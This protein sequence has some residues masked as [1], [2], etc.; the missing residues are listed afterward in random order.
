MAGNQTQ[1]EPN[2]VSAAVGLAVRQQRL[3]ADL[4]LRDL[5]ARSGV[6]SAMISRIEN[7]QVSPSLSTLEA[8]AAAL[9]VP[10]V[11]L[12]EHTLRAADINF[13]KS[14][15][16][17]PAVRIAPGHLHRYKMLGHHANAALDFTASMVTLDKS[18]DHDHPV[19][20]GQGYVFLSIVKGACVYLCGGQLFEMAAGDSL[21]F[22]SQ[23]H[24]GVKTVTSKQVTFL[25]VR[26]RLV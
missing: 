16:G 15:E 24:H 7:G 26:A 9:E 25:T 11:S 12:F 6:S 2:G 5:G 17:L 8:L 13:V 19:Y 18:E 14:G 10:V 20:T 1:G 21:S 22:D 3:R 4:T 23:L